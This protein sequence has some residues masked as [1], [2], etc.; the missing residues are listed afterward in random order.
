MLAILSRTIEKAHRFSDSLQYYWSARGVYQFIG[1]YESAG[2]LLEEVK[3]HS[4]S[5]VILDGILNPQELIQKIR[6][7]CP[8]CKI[9]LVTDSLDQSK[10][11]K[12]A[13]LCCNFGVEMLLTREDFEQPLE[14][15]SKKLCVL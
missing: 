10:N 8:K 7:A 4:Y 14:R 12:T 6:E 11:L 5:G 1:T 13:S 2:E 9:A 15:L 3:K